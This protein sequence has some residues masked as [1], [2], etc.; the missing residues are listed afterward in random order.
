[1]SFAAP[2]TLRPLNA[3]N[4]E[5][6]RAAFARVEVFDDP[7]RALDAWR[8]LPPETCGSFYQSETFVLAWL[9]VFAAREQASPSSF[10]RA[11]KRARRW[12]CCRSGCSGSAR[13]GW[14]NSSAANIPITIS[15]C[16]APDRAFSAQR[17]AGLAECGGARGPCA[18]RISIA[19]STCR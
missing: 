11:T 1:M 2:Q 16:F 7:A 9:A 4:A 17:S 12:R 19:C 14:R 13:C 8:A 5:T 15:A 10:W 3:P 6:A 18:A